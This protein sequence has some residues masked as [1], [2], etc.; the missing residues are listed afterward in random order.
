MRDDA[1]TEQ[2]ADAY[3]HLYDLVYLRAHRLS[4]ALS[5]D[6]A[7][8]GRKRARQL[9]RVLL[10]A[11][12]ELDPGPQAPPFSHA[13]RRHRLMVLRYVKGLAPQE[14]ADQ[15]AVSLRH[16]YRVHKAALEDLSILLQE[17]HTALVPAAQAGSAQAQAGRTADHLA[18]LRLEA[19]R[20]AQGSR[21]ARIG[22]VLDGVLPLINEILLLS[23]MDIRLDVPA[24]L[25]GTWVNRGILRQILLGLLGYLIERAER[26]TLVVTAQVKAGMVFVSL[27]V[28]PPAAVDGDG[29]GERLQ[30][31]AEIATLSGAHILPVHDGATMVGCELQ[32]PIA[33]RTLLVVDDNEDVLN[34]FT[35]YLRPHHY[36]VIT[37]QTGEAA[38]AQAIKAQPYAI[39]LDLMM[40][41]RDG[42]EVIQS[43]LN[44]PRTRHIPIIVCSVL[45]QK[46][47]ALSLGA[48]AF[49]EKP[50]SEQ[51]LLAAL[52]LLEET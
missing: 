39:T 50:V 17:R 44:H 5:L 25:P 11:I 37:A 4:E 46:T 43:I 8:P 48:T 45:K 47:L 51:D 2:V 38:M 52:A 7:L 1:F 32:L 15:L 10:A 28:D 41:D 20:M 33:E 42:W 6:P 14:V 49:L 26:A 29:N 19:A 22:Q 35:R 23:H 40:P 12:D 27:L 16:Y 24:S 18:L 30:E 34:L 13:W 36:R 3:E 31:L 21:Y 9:H